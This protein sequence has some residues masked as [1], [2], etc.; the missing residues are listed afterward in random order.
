MY[1]GRHGGQGRS[2]YL[3]S[4]PAVWGLYGG[5]AEE[6]PLRNLSAKGTR[7]RGKVCAKIRCLRA[8]TEKKSTA[9]D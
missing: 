7:R 8:N 5:R 3:W 2:S 9:A 6:T 1:R 4:T